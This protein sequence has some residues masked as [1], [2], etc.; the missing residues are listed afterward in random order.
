M[1]WCAAPAMMIAALG[2]AAVG[3]ADGG[4]VVLAVIGLLGF[5]FFAWAWTVWFRLWLR[6]ARGDNPGLRVDEDGFEDTSS[7][8]G[9]GRVSW[10][11]V[12]GWWDAKVGG[13]HLLF[14]ALSDDTGIRSEWRDR[15]LTKVQI[16]LNTLEGGRDEILDAFALAHGEGDARD[17]PTAPM[18]S[19]ETGPAVPVLPG[20]YGTAAAGRRGRPPG[21]RHL[22]WWLLALLVLAAVGLLSDDVVGRSITIPGGVEPTLLVLATAGLLFT[23]TIRDLFGANDAP[24]ACVVVRGAGLFGPGRR[25]GRLTVDDAVELARKRRSDGL[26]AVAR[27]DAVALVRWVLLQ[28]A[29]AALVALGMVA[30][31]GTGQSA[32]WAVLLAG[33][34]VLILSDLPRRHADVAG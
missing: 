28:L 15:P 19:E 3:F 32:W 20:V 10:E 8:R 5:G 13:Q 6:I 22:W 1:L 14:V 16:A 17:T 24:V 2:L 7:L 26:D 4:V 29:G 11:Q 30:A 12:P 25:F 18:P 27:Y 9:A 33:V 31:L 23:F 21:R 34:G